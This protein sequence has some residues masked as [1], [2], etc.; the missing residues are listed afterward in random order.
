M[1]ILAPKV[2]EGRNKANKRLKLEEIVANF[3]QVG[4]SQQHE[5]AKA[6]AMH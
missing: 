3:L 5:M 4:V 6:E 2:S 1:R